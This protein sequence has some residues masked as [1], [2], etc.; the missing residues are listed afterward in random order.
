MSKKLTTIITVFLLLVL[1]AYLVTDLTMK[2]GAGPSFSILPS[3]EAFKDRWKLLKTIQPAKGMLRAVTACADNSFA[4]GGDSFISYYSSES[5][6]IWNIYTEDPV[7][8]LSVSGNLIYSAEGRM[9][10]VYDTSGK[11]TDEWGP[12]E[13]NAIITSVT[14]NDNYVAFADAANRTVYVLN[15]KGIVAYLIGKEG[16]EFIIPSNFFDIALSNDDF[17]YVANTGNRRI[18]KRKLNGEIIN[19]LGKAGTAPDGFCGCCNPAHFIVIPNGF[20]TSEKGINRIKIL[21]SDGN[22][23]EMV[24]SVNNF[25][26][27]LPL[28]LASADGKTI[29]AANPSD[30]KVYVFVRMTGN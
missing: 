1:T 11:K 6:L 23:R 19:K 12:F 30:S 13:E 3:Q 24:S 16:Q 17:L 7:S 4:A 15:K 9:I 25:K 5:G 2:K 18:E 8:A 20:V 10:R 27:S 14:S 21:N 26:P 28:D 22:F 29:L